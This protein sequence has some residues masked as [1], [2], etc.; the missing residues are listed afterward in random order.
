[1]NCRGYAVSQ[2][3]DPEPS[4]YSNAPNIEAKTF[5]Q[6]EHSY[7]THHPGRF[8]YI[9]DDDTG[10]CFSLPYEPMRV[11]FDDFN[12][13]A[14]LS[15]IS[16]Q[17]EKL[18]LRF[19]ITLTLSKDD[20]LELWSISV[21]NQ[22]NG[23]RNVSIYPY[24]T[25]GHLSWMNQSAT[26]DPEH[27]AIVA[28]KV[29]PY[30]KVE[31]YFKNKDLHEKVCFIAEQS[32]DSWN[33]NQAKFEGEGG[34]HNPD[35]IHHDVL[36]NTEAIYETP[37]AVM[38][39]KRHLNIDDKATLRFV[40]G[41]AKSDAH[42]ADISTKYFGHK[43]E[44]S[45]QVTAYQHYMQLAQAN[46]EITTSDDVFDQFVNHWLPRQMFYLADVNRLSTDPQTRNYL[47]DNMGMIYLNPEQ[48]KN[49]F[50]FALA[51]Q[52]F[53]GA[54]PD[55]ILLHPDATLKYI[56]QVPHVDHGVWLVLFIHAYLNETNDHQILNELVGFADHEGE[57]DV[58][59][60][61]EKSLQWLLSARDE[62]GLSYIEQGDWCDP[63]NM[64]GY[65]GK[66]VSSWLS[67]ATAYAINCWQNICEDYSC[68]FNSDFNEKAVQINQTVN[69]HLWDGEWFGRG[70]T[71]DNVVFG[72]NT[73]IEGRIFL[74]PQSWAML[75]G[76][77]DFQQTQTLIEQVNQQLSTPYGLMM[78]APSYTKMR[79]D[80]G[81]VTQK[82]PGTAENGSVY[83]HAAIF[84]A[85]SLY[86]N[87]QGAAAFDVIRKMLSDDDIQTRK[88][89]P[90]FIPNYYRGAYNQYPENA[91]RSSNLFNTGT[92]AWVY[93]CILEG[94]LG[95]KGEKGH[96]TLNP[97]LPS[98]WQKVSVVRKYQGATFNVSITQSDSV[99]EQSIRVNGKAHENSITH[100]KSGTVY[101]V[102]I[103]QPFSAI[104]LD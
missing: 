25:I 44:F 82:F 46:I 59:T 29:T 85:F 6:P 69:T 41:P 61:L 4:K 84:Y 11:S 67:L 96:L 35:D 90:I 93:R 16:W 53:S 27:N 2:F 47:Q 94:L 103:I 73:D 50:L 15:D 88:Q 52:K 13:T 97:Q 60:H 21:V 91:G 100:I 14:G 99:K 75:S 37:V 42:I 78:L 64:V 40:F 26:F 57:L 86:Q 68:G 48:A 12:F 101:D 30:Q 77:A 17:I 74:N 102:E 79:E 9:K 43:P 34:L 3:M 58:K 83:N 87:Q 92:V 36:S 8:F 10:T 54:M 65:K 31:D 63:M 55:G 33:V 62:R 7:F 20:A 38:Q 56:N 76:A 22:S 23:V 1:M 81:R 39:F 72:V 104:A 51:Q 5:I 28:T 80:V 70:I 45:K 71:D 95:L 19:E 49:A 66:G 32:P 98:H 24:F 18:G 89:L